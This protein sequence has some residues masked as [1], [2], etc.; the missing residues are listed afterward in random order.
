VPGYYSEVHHVI[1]YAKCRR[2]DVNDLTFACGP[3]HCLLRPGGW[4][5]RK[6]TK[7][8]T[9]WNLSTTTRMNR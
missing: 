1:D 6:N 5:T 8:H 3:H 9:E 4:S 7:G 2:A